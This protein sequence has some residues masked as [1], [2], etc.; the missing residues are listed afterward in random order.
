MEATLSAS[1]ATPQA[2]TEATEVT[3]HPT[4]SKQQ[5]HSADAAE[6]LQTTIMSSDQAE[7]PEMGA[8]PA[9]SPATPLEETEEME[10]TPILV[11]SLQET[12]G[13]AA[14]GTRDYAAQGA[15]TP[16]GASGA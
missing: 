16:P 3:Q 8:T 6:F 10:E 14:P 9:V 11:M 15:V 2:E 7:T 13:A 5:A 4:T 12:T 1:L